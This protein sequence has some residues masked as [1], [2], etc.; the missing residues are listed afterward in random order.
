MA[1]IH[2]ERPPETDDD[3]IVS[4]MTR[5][6][7]QDRVL[8]RVDQTEEGCWEWPGS[9]TSNGYGTASY[10]RDDGI[11]RI[12]MTHR[13]V[14]EALVGP[15]PEGLDLDHLCRNR[16]CCNP[17]HLEPVPR[18]VNSHRG[19][20]YR[21]SHCIHGHEYTKENSHFNKYGHIKCRECSRQSCKKRRMAAKSNDKSSS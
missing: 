16:I 18:I 7:L 1:R 14:Y 11:Q 19:A 9:T 8:K 13:V 2:L 6:P 12:A 3:G 4:S 5:I 15:I 20:K 17:K 21:P 10:I